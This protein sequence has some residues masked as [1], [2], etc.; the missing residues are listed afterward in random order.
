MVRR[1]RPQMHNCASGNLEVPG[2]MLRIAPERRKLPPHVP[3]QH[4][5]HDCRSDADAAQDVVGCCQRAFHRTAHPGRACRE[6]QAFEDEQDSHTDEEVGERYGPH[7]T[8]TS[9]LTFFSFYHWRGGGRVANVVWCGGP[10]GLGA[11][12]AT[13]G[14]P[15][16]LLKNLK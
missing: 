1:T 2:S 13:G 9:R 11:A 8:T 12:G 6:H 4:Q 7:R 5:P 14:W 16:E 10:Y 3:D 15:E